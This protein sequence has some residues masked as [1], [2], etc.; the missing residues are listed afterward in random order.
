MFRES[1]VV[2]GLGWGRSTLLE[3]LTVGSVA[4][5][6]FRGNHQCTSFPTLGDY[7]QL[8]EITSRM[9]VSKPVVIPWFFT[10]QLRGSMVVLSVP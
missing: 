3:T 4:I 6:S 2:A 1:V 8:S 9:N 10:V 7:I 5:K